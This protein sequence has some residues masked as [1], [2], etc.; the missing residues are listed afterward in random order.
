MRP[1]LNHVITS[2]YFRGYRGEAKI[3]WISTSPNLEA[4]DNHK[5][6]GREEG[7][8]GAMGRRK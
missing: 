6:K 1:M 7:E 4:A 5:E 8:G 2:P 3:Y